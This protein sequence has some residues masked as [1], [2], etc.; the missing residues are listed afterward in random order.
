MSNTPWGHNEEV[1]L[2]EY[3]VERICSKA[4]GRSE[5][6]CLHNYPRDVYFIGNLRPVEE[7]SQIDRPSYLRDMLIKLAPV[8]F[9]AEF[10][11]Q[12]N[13]TLQV[14]ITISW[15]CYYRV[16]PTFE[17]QLEYQHIQS[18][19]NSDRADRNS[20]AE[21]NGNQ[22]LQ[23][24]TTAEES[25]E[26]RES[27]TDRRNARIPRDS[28]FIRFCKISCEANGQ[29]ILSRSSD[30][31]LAV[32]TS[33]LQN[34]INQEI[35]RAQNLAQDDTNHLRT[36]ISSHEK[37][38][39]PQTALESEQDYRNFLLSLQNDIIQQWG[40]EV[41][42]EIQR[43]EDGGGL[44]IFTEFI[45]TSPMSAN[46]PN[47]E[48]YLFD[49]N[50]TFNFTRGAVLP[51]RLN[52]VPRG[53]RYD[54][55]LWGRGFNCAVDEVEGNTQ[56]FTTTHAP[57]YQQMRFVTQTIPAAPFTTLAQ[58]PLPIL[59]LIA[60]AMRNYHQIWDQAH[61]QYIENDPN[62]ESV[63]GSEF[64]AGR[65]Q[66][67]AEIARFELG[68]ELLAN[69]SD[70]RL[71]F[72]L[73]NETFSRL[74]P[75]KTNWRLFQIVFILS[76]IP[77]IAT[78]AGI[79]NADANELEIVDIIYFP[80]GGGKTEAYL[81]TIIFHCFFD[82]LRGKTAGVTAWTRFP[83]R[84]LTL[85]QTQRVANVIGLAEIVRREH[86][87]PRLS[88]DDVDGFAVGYF[89]GQSSSPN[90]I[91]DPNR[92]RNPRAEIQVTW[93]QAN[94]S[95]TRQLWKRVIHC[96]SCK[97]ATV[98]VDFDSD[99]TRIIHR[100]TNA[101]CL[102]SEG[103]IPV[104]VV[105]NEI[106]RY[107]PSVIVGTIDKLAGVGNQRKMSQIF[108]QVDGLCSQHGYYKGICCQKDCSDSRLI[109]GPPHGLSG[110][111]LFIQDE[112]HLLKEGLGTFDGHYE[113]FIQRLQIEFNQTAPLKIIA[114][115]A[116]IEAFERQAEHL[117]G[118]SRNQARVF[119][120][121]GPSLGQSFYAETLDYPQRLFVG[122]IPHN[123]TIF[124][125]ILELIEYYSRETQHLKSIPSGDP[126]PYGGTLLPSTNEYNSL[127]D[128]YVTSLT[129]FLAGHELN[130]IRT[131]IEGDVNPNLS[132]DGL[133]NLEISELTGSTSTDDVTSI[134]EKLEKPAEHNAPHDAI[135]ATNMVSHGVD[136][137]RFNNMI[138]YGM[139]RQNAE[140]IQASSRVGRA[141][142]GIV[143]CCMHPVRERDQ[144]HYSYFK[145]FHE[146]LGQ[147]VEPVAINRW[148]RFSINHTLPGLFMAI[149]LQVIANN[150]GESNPNRY[151]MLD[152]VK[153][154][155]SEGSIRAGDF[156]AF[157]EEAYQV[158][159][160]N[161]RG[162]ESFRDEIH[163]RVQ[164]FLDQIIG[165]SSGRYV[166]D[167]LIPRPLLSLR[168]VDEPIEIEL[169][170]VG[171]QWSRR[172][173]SH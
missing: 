122:I 140:Y 68:V 21:D 106:Y 26:A 92:Q 108:G 65:Q 130:S 50:A 72:Q 125:T 30:N 160:P 35:E 161:T 6:E 14:D 45:N 105:D 78:L 53:F 121:L 31:T 93:S 71:A 44:K 28:M 107:L 172:T 149:L 151:Y 115:S 94:D 37:I 59:R 20:E 34:S 27:T 164:Q 137:D 33:N 17:Q 101:E 95:V 74:D 118:A 32:D 97:T 60:E 147:L 66:F 135:L 119:P 7:G 42:A 138:F 91:V 39:V 87:D 9:G 110:P 46:S 84:L 70:I 150:S 163:L 12:S 40:L 88:G 90:E 132:R 22:E 10:L 152:F 98:R 117:Y 83:L 153:Q 154:K 123:K 63:F 129:Y 120:G 64:D 171:S 134:L 82:R 43:E 156:I 145:K 61:Q 173:A 104:Y 3:L 103:I 128:F 96:P 131:D 16:F 99:N 100:C 77:G 139:P 41:R 73:T 162:E 67:E 141:H 48:A 158:Q 81:G 111:S 13:E 109:P 25:P 102:F 166:S 76:Q 55:N 8:A 24:Q 113:T 112:L 169:D 38:Q 11:I 52:L 80:T 23:D 79:D 49:T 146:F 4:S 75:S 57:I 133:H 47:V 58:D 148:S 19:A 29:I 155:I 86:T 127:I 18:V 116:T 51:F 15:N 170:S 126:N 69:N 168:D 56:S 89:V 159:N 62:W 143:F 85:Q 167:V 144:S 157:L 165:A 2:S 1:R 54:Q 5:N 136:V 124:N 114:S 142:V 36:N